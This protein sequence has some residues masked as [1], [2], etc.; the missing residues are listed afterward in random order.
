MADQ[1]FITRKRKKWKFAHFAQWPNCFE[2]QEVTGQNWHEY[3]ANN[4][5][6]IAEIGA[7][8]ADLSYELAAACPGQNFIAVDVKA[9]R[10]YTGAKKALEHTRDNIAFIRAHAGQLPDIFKAHTIQELWVTFP[11]PFPRARQ[12]KHRLTHALFLQHYR[13]ILVPGG[14]LR[15][16]TD[17]QELFLWSLEQLVLAGWQIRELSFD[18]HESTLPQEYKITTVY[19]RRFI[20]GGVPINYV[21]AAPPMT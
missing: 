18:L 15:F 5:P 13:T 1:L 8:T 3:F 14:V 9:D 2:A 7:G 10:L 4:H 11:D 12:A 6:L 17:N 16:K 21:S 19:E 20:A